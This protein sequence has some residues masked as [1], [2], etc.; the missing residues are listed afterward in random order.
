MQQLNLMGL[1]LDDYQGAIFSDCRKYR[2][3]LW[4]KW[5]ECKPMA[6]FIGLNP[7]TAN[8]NKSDN[9]I[10]KLCKVA[11]HNGFGGFF[12][13][14]LFALVSPYPDDLKKCENPIMDND[15]YLME[16]SEKSTKIIYCWGNFKEAQDRARQVAAMFPQPYCFVKNKNGSPKHPLYCKDESILIPFNE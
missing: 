8:E 6:M 5:N 11:S 16:Y 3:V 9:T 14:N 12:M 4:R 1:F 13:L 7:S 2:Y 15:K 10:T